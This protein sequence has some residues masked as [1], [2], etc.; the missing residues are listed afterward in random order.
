[1][2]AQAEAANITQTR[3]RSHGRWSN[4]VYV[5]VRNL[6]SRKALANNIWQMQL[7]PRALVRRKREILVYHGC[8][9]NALN[10]GRETKQGLKALNLRMKW[11]ML[12]QA[13]S[14]VR[15]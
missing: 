1:M 2:G 12:N 14:G 9:A 11:A 4:L 15:M 3:A 5:L 7:E 13:C 8:Q 6:Q 10:R